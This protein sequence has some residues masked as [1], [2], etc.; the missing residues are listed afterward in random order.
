VRD[1]LGA[2]GIHVPD[3]I[4]PNDVV[5]ELRRRA[6]SGNPVGTK[7]WPAMKS[8][9]SES[10]LRFLGIYAL[11]GF[12]VPVILLVFQLLLRAS[13]APSQDR[14]EFLSRIYIFLWP[15]SFWLMAT[16]GFRDLGSI[17]IF[18]MSIVANVLL[19]I[20][21][22]LAIWAIMSL[23]KKKLRERRHG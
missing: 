4:F 15:S 9:R 5:N 12:F 3:T 22:G 1:A 14:F 10:L 7:T 11:V 13:E 21:V 2:G 23:F 8:Y 16:D 19:Y 18:V 17:L 20:I 6:P